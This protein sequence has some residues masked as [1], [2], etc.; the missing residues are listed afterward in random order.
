MVMKYNNIMKCLI[1]DDDKFERDGLKFLLKR[2]YF[3]LKILE[4][5]NGEIA[6]DILKQNDLDF[7]ITDLHMPIMDG[8]SFLKEAKKIRDDIVYLIYS[9]FNDFNNAKEAIALKVLDFLVKPVDELEFYKTINKAMDIIKNNKKEFFV[10]NFKNAFLEDLKYENVSLDNNLIVFKTFKKLDNEEIKY[11]VE[12]IEKAF[13]LNFY[14][15]M[16][17]RNEILFFVDRIKNYDKNFSRNFSNDL[18]YVMVYSDLGKDIKTLYDDYL[19]I[20]KVLNT[21]LFLK[22]NVILYPKDY[23]KEVVYNRLK[24]DNIICEIKN[25]Y[26][27]YFYL[28]MDFK[29]VIIKKLENVSSKTIENIIS[30]KT[31][32][33][34]EKI[35]TERENKKI[36]NDFIYSI[37]DFISKNYQREISIDDIAKY[38][39]LNPNYLCTIFKQQTNSTL[40]QY[41]TKY[42]IEKA[43]VLLLETH[44]KSS[45]IAKMVGINNPSYFNL[46][47][48]NT[49]GF[50]PNLYR[51]RGIYSK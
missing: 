18:E 3:D 39:S 9:G 26:K 34:I 30:S 31:L 27:D 20:E 5:R 36:E 28:P 48:K 51:K 22:S 40:I 42:R 13:S 12:N 23:K 7:V 19:E 46:I 2:K 11:I 16:E 17:K 14:F 8:I 43:K 38:V 50:T 25:E 4:A 35:L 32:H 6:L 21:A 29:Y 10:E 41:L 44:I 37:K 15:V 47:F 24:T 45:E 49:T 33:D 1:V